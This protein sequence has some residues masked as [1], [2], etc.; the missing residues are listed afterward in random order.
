MITQ[1]K[2]LAKVA[3]IPLH[4]KHSVV[5]SEVLG[6]FIMEVKRIH[7]FSKMASLIFLSPTSFILAM[8]LIFW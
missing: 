5:K 8:I 4:E 6:V 2:I 1:A 3:D 7:T